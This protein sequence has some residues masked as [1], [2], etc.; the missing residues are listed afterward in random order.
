MLFR[1]DGGVWGTDPDGT[2]A[3]D[4]AGALARLEHFVEHVLPVFGPHEDAM[5]A[6][7]WHL[8][9]SMLSP[10]LNNGLLMPS[11][12]CD[13]VQWAYDNG[14]IPIASAEG[15][16]R[17][18]I[19]WREY[20]NGL[21]WMW[22][23]GYLEKNELG[24]V[25]P[26]PRA[27]TD[28]SSTRMRC[29]S[30]CAG[31]VQERGW[32]HHIQRLMVLG[33]WALLAGVDPVQINDW[34]LELFADAFDWVVTPNVMGMSQYADP[35]FTTKPYVAGGA[36]IDRMSDHCRGCAYDP[37]RAMGPTACPFTTLYW[38]FVDRHA[39][40]LAGNPRTG[41]VVA[42]WRRRAPADRAAI[43]ARAEIGRA[44]V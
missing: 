9:H 19:G 18:I 30:L 31:A 33:N 38:D 25:R 4:R 28:P 41:T 23:P 12:V 1:S 21:Y 37:H 17:Q 15:F 34:F 16:V 20:V 40:L 13:A 10:Y 29:V 7:N 42:A 43:L 11:D 44:H 5:L 24:A 35:G 14:R 8:A 39:P 2:W 22:M 36:Y 6:G 32:A 27:F 3:T 26:L